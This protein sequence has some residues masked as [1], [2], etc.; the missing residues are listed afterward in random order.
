MWVRSKG[1]ETG[2]IF[3]FGLAV[4]GAETVLGMV[5]GWFRTLAEVIQNVAAVLV[6]A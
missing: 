1:L 6:V 2:K 4:L 3:R 5:Q